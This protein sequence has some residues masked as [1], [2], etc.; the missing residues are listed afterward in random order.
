MD[1]SMKEAFNKTKLMDL[2]YINGLMEKFTR[3]NG[4][5]I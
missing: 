4:K 3:D 1:Q 2:E 5:A